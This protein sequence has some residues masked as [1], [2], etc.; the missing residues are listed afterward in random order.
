MS[1]IGDRSEGGVS[2]RGLLAAGGGAAAAAGLTLG[3]TPA[4]EAAVTS[5]T[6]DVVVVGGGISGLTAARRL[7]QAGRSVLVLEASDHVGG[8]AINHD[9]GNGVITE[10]GGEYVGPGQDR[11][12]AL[13][14]E[15]GL[16]TF[17]TY[18]EGQ[19]IY[20]RNGNRQTFTEGSIPPLGPD[21]LVDWTQMVTRLEQ[22]ASTVPVEAPWRAEHA[23]ERDGMTFG[24]WIDANS[25]SA[26]AKWLLVLGLTTIFGEDL[27]ETS[28][29][30]ALHALHCCGGVEH[31]FSVTGGL[32]ESRVAGGSH[33]ISLKLA[34]QLGRRVITN[35]PVTA[36]R[37]ENGGA[38]V[39]SERV[40]VRCKRVIVAMTP[41]DADFIRFTPDLPTRRA[42]LQGKWRNGTMFKLFAVYDKPFWRD[43]G[44]SGQAWTD[45]PTAPFV[46][47][48]SPE[49]GNVG[50]LLTFIGT[51]DAGDG[52]K[53][54][55]AVLDN[56]DARRAS[57]I[58]DLT[59]LFGPKAA[60][61]IAYADKDRIDEPWIN[62]CIA[63]RAGRD[64][65]IHERVDRPGGPD[66]LGRN[67]DR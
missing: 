54:S 14:D 63:T 39:T 11:V 1:E 37:Q 66:P 45:L 65:P 23:L 59:T 21:A 33:Q 8:R 43:M 49:D 58:N 67:G 44:F 42:V 6:A 50:I 36:I 30:R 48:N 46:A 22:M 52:P 47:D 60:Q 38:V 26:E 10:A 5:T 32:Q 57:Y 16:R 62:G 51:A 56:R 9:V 31:M 53:W 34:E 55:D 61:P 41:A 27:H 13:I 64:H 35:S 19:C 18:I 15:L 24:A 29:L 2:R 28:F 25:I 3:R 7:A 4:A 40:E 20:L 12:L 17:K